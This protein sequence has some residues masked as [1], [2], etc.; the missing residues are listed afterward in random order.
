MADVWGTIFRDEWEGRP[1]PHRIERDDGL[2]DDFPSAAHYF[3][4]PRSEP[5]RT[6]LD[7]LEGP[8]LDLGAGV[9]SYSL[10]LQ[11]RGLRVTA[12]DLSPG[13]IE[14]CR[15]R[16]CRDARVMDVRTVELLAGE[17]RGVIVMGN[18]L[19]VQQTPESLPRFLRTLRRATAGG[20]RLVVTTID[21]LVTDRPEHLA[22]HQ[23][24]REHGLPVGLTKIRL[25]YRDLVDDWIQLWLPTTEELDAAVGRSGWKR[26][27]RYRTGP[28]RTDC[29]L[30]DP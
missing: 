26:E 8:V 24:N 2:I 10:Y 13:A 20:G 7:R 12:G 21:P 4:A 23:R 17:Y 6:L 5:E 22:Y 29:Y 14:L 9:G 28:F 30:A 18:T 11:Q 19:G 1:A 27:H 3:E 15:L 16:G 25:R